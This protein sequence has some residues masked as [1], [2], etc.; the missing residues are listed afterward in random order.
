MSAPDLFSQPPMEVAR[1]K[2][3]TAMLIVAVNSGEEFQRLARAFIPKYLAEHG[4][5]SGE[6]ITDACKAAQIIPHNDKAFGPAYTSLSRAGII[7]KDMS[8]PPGPR[9]K[10]HASGIAWRWKLKT[11]QP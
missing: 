5:M 7:E 6:D 10:G 9:R 2:R 11:K 1:K 3:D 8:T 4:P